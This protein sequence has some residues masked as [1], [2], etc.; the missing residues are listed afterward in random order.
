VDHQSKGPGPS[1]ETTIHEAVRAILGQV[2]HRAPLFLY[3]SVFFPDR[4]S[5]TTF[6]PLP[7]Q[8]VG[9]PPDRDACAADILRVLREVGHRL[10][11]TPLLTA[12]S[13]RGIEWSERKVAGVCARLVNEGVLTNPKS[14]GKHL[15]YGFPEWD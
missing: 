11:T 7:N 1:I 14:G 10:T 3:L 4:T 8:T 15:G 5:A 12:L 2:Q 13:Q 6:I 9:E